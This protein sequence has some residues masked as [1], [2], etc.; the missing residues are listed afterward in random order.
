MGPFRGEL[1]WLSNFWP[2]RVKFAG[3]TFPCVENA[4]QAG[5]CEHTDDIPRFLLGAELKFPVDHLFAREDCR[6][7][8]RFRQ[9]EARLHAQPAPS[10][11][12][13]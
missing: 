8:A 3:Y 2:A 7:E 6:T 4:Y 5:K 12:L 10:E 13:T 1:R 9:R 11:V